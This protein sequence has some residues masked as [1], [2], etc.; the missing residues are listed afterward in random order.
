MDFTAQFEALRHLSTLLTKKE[1]VPDELWAQAGMKKDARLKDV[2]AQ[3]TTLKKRVSHQSKAELQAQEGDEEGEAPQ[4][5]KKKGKK[6]EGDRRSGNDKKQLSMAVNRGDY[7][8]QV[9]LI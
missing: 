7:D 3:I 2:N 1:A 4:E 9:D 5:E 6:M 8:M